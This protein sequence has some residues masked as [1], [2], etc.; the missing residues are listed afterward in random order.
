MG[1]SKSTKNKATQNSTKNSAK[2]TTKNTSNVK[3]IIPDEQERRD[4]PGGE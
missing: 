1:R 3:D 2:D 4:G